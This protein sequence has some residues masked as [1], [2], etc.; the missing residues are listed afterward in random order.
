MWVV[1]TLYFSMSRSMLLGRP[2]VHQ[3]DGVTNV[4]RRAPEA[5]HRRVVER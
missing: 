5:Q 1:V 3:H 4:Q 2:L